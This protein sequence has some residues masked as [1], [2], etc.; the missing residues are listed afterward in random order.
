MVYPDLFPK[1]CNEYSDVYG[2]CDMEYKW[3]EKSLND[4]FKNPSARQVATL[5]IIDQNHILINHLPKKW[6]GKDE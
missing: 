5:R 1:L 2:A 3:Y 6:I 4:Y